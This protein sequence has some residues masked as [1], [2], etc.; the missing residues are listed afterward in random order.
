MVT[1]R[2]G[3]V[4]TSPSSGVPGSFGLPQHGDTGVQPG[5]GQLPTYGF[6]DNGQEPDQLQDRTSQNLLFGVS[7]DQPLARTFGKPKDLAANNILPGSFCPPTTPD[8]PAMNSGII[9]AGS[10]DDSGLFQRSSAWSSIQTGPP[11]RS[12]TKVL[13]SSPAYLHFWL[14]GHLCFFS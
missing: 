13:P 1:S 14:F 9:S 3:R 10:L 8:L 12:F 5:L 7:I 6:R 11:L 4:E 2:L